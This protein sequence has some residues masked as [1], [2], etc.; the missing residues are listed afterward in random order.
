MMKRISILSIF[1]CILFAVVACSNNDDDH[2]NNISYIKSKIAG[3]WKSSQSYEVIKY[4]SVSEVKVNMIVG[5]LGD[6]AVMDVNG[7]LISDGVKSYW[8]F[9]GSVFTVYFPSSTGYTIK[10]LDIEHMDS[11][12][13]ALS[14]VTS[15]NDNVK[16][17]YKILDFSSYKRVK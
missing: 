17:E 9:D 2:E 1:F 10:N 16:G 13:I 5:L 7:N 8:D 14:Q 11:D 3:T 6:S 12:S 4:S 15:G